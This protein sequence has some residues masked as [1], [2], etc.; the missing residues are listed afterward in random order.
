MV[1]YD[2]STSCELRKPAGIEAGSRQYVRQD[3]IGTRTA[4]RM[5]FVPQDKPVLHSYSN[6]W[7]SFLCPLKPSRLR[8]FV[9]QSRASIRGR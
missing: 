6:P 5:P 8:S 4:R 3:S 2:K 9:I 7:L 1:S